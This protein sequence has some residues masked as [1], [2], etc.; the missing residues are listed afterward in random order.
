[1]KP[2]DIFRWSWKDGKGAKLDPYWCMSHIAVV[3]DD[4]SLVDTYWAGTG[5][6]RFTQDEAKDKIDLVY[7]GNFE[8]LDKSQPCY[9]SYYDDKDCVDLSHANNSRGQFY[10]RK[11]AVK[12]LVKMEK[13][14]RRVLL[15]Y[16]SEADCATRRLEET[17]KDLRE[18]NIDSYVNAPDGVCL[19]DDHYQDGQGY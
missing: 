16:K 15:Y 3:R 5:D 14:M 7:V 9:R 18:L 4:L 11:G 19:S 10:L 17:R 8:D 12:S 2:G 1:M 6:T 13:I